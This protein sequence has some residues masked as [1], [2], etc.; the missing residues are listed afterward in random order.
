MTIQKEDKVGNGSER[1]LA[2]WQLSVES[3]GCNIRMVKRNILRREKKEG[4]SKVTVRKSPKLIKRQGESLYF[5]NKENTAVDGSVT[6][7]KTKKE[8][9]ATEETFAKID[10]HV[11]KSGME[12]SLNL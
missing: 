12:A 3:S 6:K 11:I 10:A 1:L 2:K 7:R 8:I 4:D 9:Y 5:V